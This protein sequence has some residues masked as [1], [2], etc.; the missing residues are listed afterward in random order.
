MCEI[1]RGGPKNHRYI[2]WV[3]WSGG[4]GYRLLV[5][6]TD[7]EGNRRM[8]QRLF[9]LRQYDLPRNELL[10]IEI[11]RRDRLISKLGT[12]RWSKRDL[13]IAQKILNHGRPRKKRS[14]ICMREE[15]YRNLSAKLRGS[16]ITPGSDEYEVARRVYNGMIDRRPDSIVRCADVTDVVTAVNFARNEDL[17]LGC[18]GAATMVR[19]WASATAESGHGA[20]DWTGAGLRAALKRKRH[21]GS[22][23]I[24][25][26]SAP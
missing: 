20:T 7:E 2:Q 12:G 25:T 9:S 21:P 24:F 4:L 3:N 15:A 17:E 11:D 8:I 14:E 13:R 5:P 22:S 6:Y 18:V 23:S 19:H 10:S 16:V 26:G 1:K